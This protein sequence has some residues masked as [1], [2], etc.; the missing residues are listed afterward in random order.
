VH[1]KWIGIRQEVDRIGK[2]YTQFPN[3]SANYC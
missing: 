1:R 2:F 3:F